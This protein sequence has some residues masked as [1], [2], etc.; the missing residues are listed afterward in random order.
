MIR[1][2]DGVV[3]VEVHEPKGML[4][5]VL[6]AINGIVGTLTG[7]EP[8]GLLQQLQNAVGDRATVTR[9]PRDQP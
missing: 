6:D 2:A 7:Q 3:R 5:Q 9:D 4:G 1:S 8:D